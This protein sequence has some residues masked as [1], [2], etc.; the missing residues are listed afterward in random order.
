[1]SPANF[2]GGGQQLARGVQ[3]PVEVKTEMVA[4]EKVSGKRGG[5]CPDLGAD[6]IGGVP[7]GNAVR[8]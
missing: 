1:M 5:G 4:T 7:V 6:I 2:H 3:Q 8:V